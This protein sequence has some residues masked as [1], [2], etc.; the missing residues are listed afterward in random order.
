MPGR[1]TGVDHVRAGKPTQHNYSLCYSPENSAVSCADHRRAIRPRILQFHARI[2]ATPGENVVGGSEKLR[3]RSL[4]RAP[5]VFGPAW[6][7]HPKEAARVRAIFE[8]Y[9]QHRSLE[10]SVRELAR[11]RW[12]SKRRHNQHGDTCGGRAFTRGSLHRLLTNVAYTGQVR[13]HNQLYPG[14][15]SAIVPPEIWQPCAGPSP[16]Q[17]F[18]STGPGRKPLRRPPAGT[19][20]LYV[21][22][23]RHDADLLSP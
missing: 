2:I 20:L 8:L 19:A 4:I 15:Q 16:E 13:Y 22:S 3:R 1:A 10:G 6:S 9:L 21:L 11:R 18:P 14:E 17:S 23:L 7:V 12:R 5:G